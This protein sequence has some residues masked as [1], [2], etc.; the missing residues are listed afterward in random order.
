MRK[1]KF[2]SRRSSQ[3]KLFPFS[4]KILAFSIFIILI[5]LVVYVFFFSDFLKIKNIQ[6]NTIQ[7]NCATKENILNNLSINDKNILLINQKQIKDKLKSKFQCIKVVEISRKLPSDI[8]ISVFGRQA[9]MIIDVRY[10][11][12]S[13]SGVIDN[14]SQED[15]SQSA[16]SS[17][18]GQLFLV[19]KEG[20]LFAQKTID[21]NVPKVVYLNTDL[22]LESK[23]NKKYI[24]NLE[25][26]FARFKELGL[27]IK[28]VSIYPP[29]SVL[30]VSL[31]NI[32]FN[33][34]GDI[35]KQLAALQLILGQAKIDKASMIF[36]DLRFD[37][38]IVKYATRSK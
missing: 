4:F 1:T 21:I 22:R 2:K 12:A 11:E 36:I 6:I 10:T 35:L 14:L 7:T 8:T 26:I 27:N 16:V 29:D 13:I 25:D 20:E 32:I 31:S 5:F 15:A 38:P 3:K 34:Q 18:S 28:E 33:I 30:V 17:S 9:V 24:H 19:D 37:K 23:L